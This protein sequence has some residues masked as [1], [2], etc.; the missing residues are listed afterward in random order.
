MREKVTGQRHGSAPEDAST[1]GPWERQEDPALEPR[2]ER[3]PAGALTLHFRGCERISFCHFEAPVRG[4]LLGGS[5]EQTQR[6][7]GVY[8]LP[9][10][11]ATSCPAVSLPRVPGKHPPRA[12][13]KGPAEEPG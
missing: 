5:R 3:D 6:L 7:G 2:R 10:A 12:P 13:S 8:F 1:T 9:G 4:T 11:Q